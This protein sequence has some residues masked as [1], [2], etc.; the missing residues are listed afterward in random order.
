MFAPAD[1]EVIKQSDRFEMLSKSTDE[2]LLNRKGVSWDLRLYLKNLNI[3]LEQVTFPITF[4]HG[5]LDR[6][7]PI[8]VARLMVS[9]MPNAKLITYDNE[10]HLSTFYNHFLDAA[11]QL[12]CTKSSN[13]NSTNAQH[14]VYCYAGGRENNPQL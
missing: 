4:Y 3:E 8:E 6:N 5:E 9:K 1:Y 14:A 13:K 10:A 11:K 2:A 7:M 12:L